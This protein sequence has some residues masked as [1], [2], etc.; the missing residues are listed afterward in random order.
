MTM[1]K[2]SMGSQPTD[3]TVHVVREGGQGQ[4]GTPGTVNDISP[5]QR[6]PPRASGGGDW[7]K[8]LGSGKD[9]AKQSMGPEAPKS[10]E[11]LTG[12]LALAKKWLPMMAGVTTVAGIIK[13]SSIF[14]AT[15]EIIME[16]LGMIM[17]LI[18]MPFLLPL[19]QLMIP[20]M[21]PL[22]KVVNWFVSTFMGKS[23]KD[24]MKEAGAPGWLQG[25]ASVF[26][27]VPGGKLLWKAGEG[28]A[29]KPGEELGT[30]GSLL[31]QSMKAVTG[32]TSSVGSML[33]GLGHV[34]GFAGGLPYVPTTMPA[35]LHRGERVVT[36]ADNAS[37]G[38][39]TQMFHNQFDIHVAN[40]V[41]AMLLDQRI[42]DRLESR[43]GNRMRR[44]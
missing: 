26:D 32:L 4:R 33:G 12:M 15:M 10:A 2:G 29:G 13:K 20:I 40:N 27:K 1:G 25:I 8:I 37:G 39:G 28:I 44:N 42:A 3:I 22:A 17:D 19:I 36:A 24:E 18:L 31:D 16:T 41:D 21:E 5:G 30:G 35:V 14:G 11:A 23:A 9:A 6:N 38:S 43:L 34:L 7:D